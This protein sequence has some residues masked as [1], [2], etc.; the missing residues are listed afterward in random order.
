MKEQG[1]EEVPSSPPLWGEERRV[2]PQTHASFEDKK[3]LKNVWPFIPLRRGSKPPVL[4]LGTVSTLST[5]ALSTSKTQH[6]SSRSC[7]QGLA[8]HTA[9]SYTSCLP[10]T[11]LEED[12]RALRH[13]IDQQQQVRRWSGRKLPPRKQA[14]L[15]SP[16]G[17]WHPTPPRRHA[18]ATSRLHSHM[19]QQHKETLLHPGCRWP[20]PLPSLPVFLACSTS[21]HLR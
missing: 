4:Q 9:I 20:L 21:R 19:I 8:K 12:F 10:V 15:A 18:T 17:R 6:S 2:P 5:G 3:V 13:H 16:S 14:P 11:G 1:E 7:W